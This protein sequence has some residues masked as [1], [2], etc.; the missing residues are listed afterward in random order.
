MALPLCLPS[1]QARSASSNSGLTGPARP[2]SFTMFQ[3]RRSR[4]WPRSI[5]R[6]LECAAME[7]PLTPLDFF[8][9]ARRLYGGRPAVVD[10]GLHLTYEQFGGRCDRWSGWLQASGVAKGDRVAYICPNT[11]AQ[12]ESF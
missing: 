12:L 10:G 8:R 11:H 6:D 2:W 1:I 5:D 9:R 7:V 3:F 4:F